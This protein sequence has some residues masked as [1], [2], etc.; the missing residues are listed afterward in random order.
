MQPRRRVA[1]IHRAVASLDCGVFGSASCSRMQSQSARASTWLLLRT[2]TL[3]FPVKRPVPTS[4]RTRERPLSGSGPRASAPLLLS[5]GASAR[6]A[7]RT[8]LSGLVSTPW[9]SRRAPPNTMLLATYTSCPRKRAAKWTIAVTSFKTKFCCRQFRKNSAGESSHPT[10]NLVTTSG[11]RTWILR[12]LVSGRRNWT[13]SQTGWTNGSTHVALT[14]CT[15]CLSASN[16][17]LSGEADSFSSCS[18][19]TKYCTVKAWSA[20]LPLLPKNTAN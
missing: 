18:S 10:M 12:G 4:T 7:T 1:L 9:C 8:K 15:T 11:N 2:T 5:P 13:R 16:C 3:A 14:R 6:R 17:W 19:R 20:A